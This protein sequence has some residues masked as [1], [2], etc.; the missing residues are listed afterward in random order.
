MIQL[1]IVTPI[2]GNEDKLLLFLESIKHLNNGGI[3]YEIIIIDD[4]SPI[5]LVNIFSKFK[6]ENSDLQITL[7]RNEINLGRSKSRNLGLYQASGSIVLFLDVDNLPTIGAFHKIY[8][9]FSDP[10]VSSVRGNVLC[11]TERESRSA[12]IRF[13]NQRYLGSRGTPS[14][15]LPFK[16]FASDALA[17]RRLELLELG[18]FDEDFVKYGCEDEELGQ[19]YKKNNKSFYFCKEAKFID[20]DTPTLDREYQRMISYAQYSFPLLK[21]KHPGIES[22]ALMHHIERPEFSVSKI[23]LKIFLTSFLSL[24]VKYILNSIDNSRI[25]PSKHLYLYVIATGYLIG[26]NRRR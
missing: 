21:K 18:G 3:S 12:Y 20:S 14:G 22:D 4:G 9:A 11:P 19:R 10:N 25:N 5:S 8:H 7:I 26:F 13:F 24:P 16:F 15:P 23:I 2:L 1:S 17:V 6:A